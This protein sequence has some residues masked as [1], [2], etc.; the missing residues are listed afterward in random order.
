MCLID[1]HA[2]FP[3]RFENREKNRKKYTTKKLKDDQVESLPSYTLWSFSV[4][5]YV[6]FMSPC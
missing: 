5:S 3:Y 6:I 2:Q 1:F 4:F